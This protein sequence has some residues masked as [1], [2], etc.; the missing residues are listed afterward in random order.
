LRDGVQRDA[1][2]IWNNGVSRRLGRAAAWLFGAG[3]RIF[4]NPR[5][6]VLLRIYHV[7]DLAPTVV[8]IGGRVG[9]AQVG[10]VERRILIRRVDGGDELL[11]LM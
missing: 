4:A 2:A 6:Q 3:R 9:Q 8:V 10:V 5:K 11:R 7:R 1:A